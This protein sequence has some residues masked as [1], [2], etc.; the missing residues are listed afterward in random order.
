MAK[1]KRANRAIRVEGYGPLARKLATRGVNAEKVKARLKTQHI[2]TPSWGY[3]QSGTRFGIFDQPGAA[4]DVYEKLADA[5]MVHRLTGVAPTVA[6][7]IPWD[8]VDDWKALRRYARRLGVDIGAINPNVFQDQDYKLGSTT[9]PKASIRR[10]ATKHMLECVEIMKATGS[11]VLS[12]WFA[13]G[14]NYP[15]QGHI[16]SR[17]RWMEASLAEVYEALPAGARML[18][19]YKF[20]EPAFYHTDIPDYGVALDMSKKLGRKAQVLVDLGHHPLGTNIEQIVAY[21]IDEG[22]MGGFHFNAKKFADDDLTVGSINPYELFL[23]FNE[24]IDGELDPSV[25]NLDIAYMIDQSHNI[26]PKIEAMLQSV[27]TI[28]E[29]YAKALCVDRKGLAAAQKAGDVVAAEECLKA[30]FNTDV[31]P[32][33]AAARKEMGLEPDVIKAYRRSGY[34]EQIAEERG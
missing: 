5:A 11:K 10:K 27:D 32:I 30:A 24:I 22:K 18:I 9:N 23:I 16:R 1:A 8:W 6:L 28:Q 14:T 33:I 15:G 29:T 17:K 2:E 7:H 13:D 20:F 19:E 21:L 34:A 25:K 12:L 26:K 31:R 4:R 3:A